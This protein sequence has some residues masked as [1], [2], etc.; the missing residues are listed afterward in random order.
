MR[1]LA[2]L[3][4]CLLASSA[5]AAD[6]APGKGAISE[7]AKAGA[8]IAKAHNGYPLH[9]YVLYAVRDAR[10]LDP[11][12]GNVDAVVLITPLEHV[13]HA[14]YLAA[15]SGRKF[16]PAQVPLAT[17]LEVR[18]FAHGN[19]GGDMDFLGRFSDA[20]LQLD[21]TSYAS[22]GKE[23]SLVSEG[24]Y[25]LAKGDRDRWVG[26]VT[27]RFEPGA[28][29]PLAHGAGQLEFRDAGGK[30]FSLPIDLARYR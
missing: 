5:G 29:A 10:D 14:A 2:W 19:Q 9:D 16:D 22:S 17:G 30:A 1:K 25:P 15:I 28:A 23:Y 26:T 3:A 27:Y 8:S 4:A 21:G 7:A 20:T 18:I 11:A 13:R 12:D 24:V 6:F